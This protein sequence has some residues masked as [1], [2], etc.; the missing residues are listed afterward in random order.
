MTAF[1]PVPLV[2]MRRHSLW[3]LLSL[4]VM[5]LAIVSLAGCSEA[6]P[7][8]E[9]QQVFPV[10]LV[11]LDAGREASLLRYPGEVKASERSELSFRVGGELQELAVNAG[12][13]VQ[14]GDVIARLDDRD[15][16]SQVNN[17]R[18]SFE[19]AEATHERMRVSLERNAISRS[20]YDEARAEYLSAQANLSQA[21]DQLSY[22]VLRAPFDGVIA[23]VPVDNYQVVGAQ[24]TVAVLQQPG[25]IDV[26]FQLPEQQVRRIDKQRAEEV[27]ESSTD[28]VWI[29]FTNGGKRYPAQYREHDSSVSEGSLSYEVTLTLPEPDDITVL[30]GMSATVLMDI[31]ALTGEQVRP[32]RVPVTAVTTRNETPDQV[33]VWRY[34]P[35]DSSDSQSSGQVEPVPVTPGRITGQGILVEGDLAVGDR[36]VAAGSQALREDMRVRP[37]RKE[38]GL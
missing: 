8:L 11:T 19:L 12:D 20:R 35:D 26:T 2:V 3:G 25:S 18:S 4:A 36:L 10:K 14:A 24:Q 28:V 7:S 34:I 22:T 30:S 5:S 33:L 6:A 38:E 13:E 1:R 15:A 21:E 9:K 17:A 23:S 32:W 29:E 37:W 31:Q 16:H 27:R